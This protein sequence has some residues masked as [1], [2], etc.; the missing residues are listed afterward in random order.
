MADKI[1]FEFVIFLCV[2][3]IGIMCEMLATTKDLSSIIFYGIGIVILLFLTA[4]FLR[5]SIHGESENKKDKEST[6]KFYGIV[7]VISIMI[8]M[9]LISFG[10]NH[11]AFCI[12]TSIVWTLACFSR[13]AMLWDLF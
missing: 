7:G 2:C 11:I 3:F 4:I 12:V 8:M 9:I 6:K 1:K 10:V 5:I 13:V